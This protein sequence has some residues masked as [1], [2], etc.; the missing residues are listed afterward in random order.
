MTGYLGQTVVE[1]TAHDESEVVLRC[2]ACHGLKIWSSRGYDSTLSELVRLAA[3][4]DRRIHDQG[5]VALRDHA[6]QRDG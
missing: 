3:D 4:H 1:S 2:E 6:T 5:E